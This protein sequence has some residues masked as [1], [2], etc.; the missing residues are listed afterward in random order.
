MPPLDRGE[1]QGLEQAEDLNH[2]PLSQD[3]SHLILSVSHVC[4][5][6]GAPLPDPWLSPALDQLQEIS[7][8]VNVQQMM[9]NLGGMEHLLGS[10]GGEGRL[11]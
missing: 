1:N 2:L 9:G 11:P 3:L 7:E 4:S 8:K 5:G 6:V 10:L